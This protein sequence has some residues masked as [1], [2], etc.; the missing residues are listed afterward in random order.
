MEMIKTE[1]LVELA[2]NHLSVHIKNE[3]S[4]KKLL[5][6]NEKIMMDGQMKNE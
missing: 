1:K 6:S 2:G 5:S 4:A 3:L